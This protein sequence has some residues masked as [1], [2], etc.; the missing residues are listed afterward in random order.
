MYLA[1]R[2]KNSLQDSLYL[3]TNILRYNKDNK[4]AYDILQRHFKIKEDQSR[5]ILKDN[6][7]SI[8]I[9]KEIRVFPPPNR[10]GV[11]AIVHEVILKNQHTASYWHFKVISF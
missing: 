9:P 2:N 3:S 6:N 8:Y 11:T 4:A 5:K 1:E 7:R 10:P